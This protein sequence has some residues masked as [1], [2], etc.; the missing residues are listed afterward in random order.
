MNNLVL[1]H[2]LAFDVEEAMLGGPGKS[3]GGSGEGVR[4]LLI[5]AILEAV[6]EHVRS[7]LDPD[8]EIKI[9]GQSGGNYPLAQWGE[10]TIRRPS[11]PKLRVSANGEPV[12]VAVKLW[13]DQSNWQSVRIGFI[14]PRFE[15]PDPSRASLTTALLPLFSVAHAD[16]WC[17]AAEWPSKPFN[18]WWDKRFLIDFGYAA[19][20]TRMDANA[21][22]RPEI[23]EFG[24]RLV[25]IAVATAKAVPVEWSARPTIS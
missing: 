25:D 13:N 11:W 2:E 20:R 16:D 12:P 4:Q 21:A 19:Y 24:D 22:Q 18:N 7:K 6:R 3:M 8:W 14:V 5:K 15:F 23:N 1:R 17:A 10:M 9:S